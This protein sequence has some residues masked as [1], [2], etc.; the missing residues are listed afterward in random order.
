MTPTDYSPTTTRRIQ[1]GAGVLIALFVLVALFGLF[2]PAPWS[3]LGQYEQRDQTPVQMDVPEG[4]ELSTP[5]Q[6]PGTNV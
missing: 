4:W 2:F 3:P 1:I 6:E 5:N